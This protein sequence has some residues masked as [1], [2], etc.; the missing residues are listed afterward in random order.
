[1]TQQ[2]CYWPG[3]LKMCTFGCDVRFASCPGCVQY[4]WSPL[5]LV[6]SPSVQTASSSHM[7]EANPEPQALHASGQ[8]TTSTAPL[9]GG[10]SA[11]LPSDAAR[12]EASS[13][14]AE[15]ARNASPTRADTTVGK[16][17][18]CTACRC[19]K[20]VAGYS[21]KCHCRRHCHCHCH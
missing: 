3:M 4:L 12:K 11:E 13:I 2:Q 17:L 19:A 15:S 21:G 20:E 1:V 8:H 16:T 18:L 9:R 10:T 5:P 6:T 7:T 14:R